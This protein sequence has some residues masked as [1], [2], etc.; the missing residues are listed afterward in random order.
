MDS[1]KDVEFLGAL[2]G[3]A[4]VAIMVDAV[5]EVFE[6]RLITRL[7]GCPDFVAGMINMR[8]S[9]I[10]VLNPWT[11]SMEAHAVKKIVVLKTA[12]GPVGLLIT[13]LMDLIKFPD[14]AGIEKLPAELSATADAFDAQARADETYYLFNVEKYIADTLSPLARKA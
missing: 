9:V 7:P 8:G 12:E 6:T 2:A 1:L 14:F 10:P 3:K 13:R 4:R 5:Q 11:L